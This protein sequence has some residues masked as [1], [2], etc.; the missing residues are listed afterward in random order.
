MIFLKMI[1]R[2]I[3]EKTEHS[4]LKMAIKI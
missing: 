1:K 4:P 3:K 2:I